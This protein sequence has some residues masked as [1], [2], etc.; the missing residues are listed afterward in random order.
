[1]KN[2]ERDENHLYENWKNK[3]LNFKPRKTQN[4]H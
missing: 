2:G 1:M 4:H 3:T